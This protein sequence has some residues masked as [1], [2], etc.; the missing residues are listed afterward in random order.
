MKSDDISIN[1]QTNHHDL[2]MSNT[3]LDNVVSINVSILPCLAVRRRV[4]DAEVKS[5]LHVDYRAKC[6]LLSSPL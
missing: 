1:N 4:H 6:C 2:V 3:T 5:C